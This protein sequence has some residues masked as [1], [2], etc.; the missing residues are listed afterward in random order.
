MYDNDKYTI[1]GNRGSVL[2]EAVTAI[3]IKR[4]GN[5]PSA[6]VVAALDNGLSVVLHD[7]DLESIRSVSSEI[8]R[9][10]REHVIWRMNNCL[11]SDDDE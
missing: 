2:T 11:R 8:Y 6:E 3:S 7:D 10:W 1:G 9:V 4:I 5:G